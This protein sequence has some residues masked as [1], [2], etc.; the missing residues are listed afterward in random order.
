V[1]GQVQVTGDWVEKKVTHCLDVEG[2]SGA[3]LFVMS[4]S[5][6]PRFTRNEVSMYPGQQPYGYPPQEMTLFHNGDCLVTTSRVQVRGTM[7]PLGGLTAVNVS[8]KSGQRG[9]GIVLAIL[10]LVIA[11][12]VPPLGLVMLLIGVVVALVSGDKFFLVLMTA[13]GQLN[14]LESSDE[15][16]VRQAAGAIAQALAYRR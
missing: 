8:K 14:V 10:G 2:G 5:K 12:A 3:P 15:N 7:Y 16:A 4:L 13:G 9:A 11:L 6:V 1:T